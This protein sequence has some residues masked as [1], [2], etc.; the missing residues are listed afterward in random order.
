MLLFVDSFFL[1]PLFCLQF[2]NVGVGVGFWALYMEIEVIYSIFS[3]YSQSVC[4]LNKEP[5]FYLYLHLFICSEK[6]FEFIFSVC[7]SF[8]FCIKS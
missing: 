8:S 6:S 3:V 7:T 1:L 2:V 4:D 5:I